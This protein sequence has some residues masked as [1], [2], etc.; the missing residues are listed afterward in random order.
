MCRR[1]YCPPIDDDDD[2]D[3]HDDDDDDDDD[4][5]RYPYAKNRAARALMNMSVGDAVEFVKSAAK[6]G[7]EMQ[8]THQES[9]AAAA[10]RR[11]KRER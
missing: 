11:R 8:R 7:A 9:A 6:I 1:L 2:H 4:D 10:E 3:D 5:D